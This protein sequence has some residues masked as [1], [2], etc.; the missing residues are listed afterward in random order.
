PI[1]T[2]GS[3]PLSSLASMLSKPGDPSTVAAETHSDKIR[4][5]SKYLLNFITQNIAKPAVIVVDQFEEL[6][7][8]CKDREARRM[9]VNN[10]LALENTKHKV[11]LCSTLE[12]IGGGGGFK[13]RQASFQKIYE[14]GRALL[15]RLGGTELSDAIVRPADL[16][17]FKFKDHTVKRIV[18]EI[19]TLP[20][21]LPLLQFTLIK[22][23]DKRGTHDEYFAEVGGCRQILKQ[24]A[25]EF[26]RELD[27]AD[28][29]LAEQILGSMITFEYKYQARFKPVLLIPHPVPVRFE[30]LSDLG[31]P[32]HVRTM[33][34]RMNKA[35]LIR[36]SASSIPED[37]QIE[38]VHESLIRDWLFLAQLVER[39]KRTR[40][41]IAAFTFV[42]ALILF[43]AFAGVTAVGAY[44]W[45]QKRKAHEK[46]QQWAAA[47]RKHLNDRRLDSALLLSLAAYITD[48]ADD[49]VYVR[50]ALLSSLLFHPSPKGF[51]AHQGIGDV[52]FSPDGKLL[53]A[54]D[55]DGKITFWKLI[56]GSPVRDSNGTPVTDGQSI[57]DPLIKGEQIA[58]IMFSHDGQWLASGG[59]GAVTL[60][61]VVPPRQQIRVLSAPDARRISVISLSRDSKNLAALAE[62]VVVIWDTGSGSTLPVPVKAPETITTIALSNNGEILATGDNDGTVEL[63]DVTRKR[64]LKTLGTCACVK[65]LAETDNVISSIAFSPDDE[66]IAISGTEETILWSVSSGEQLAK[67]S[68]S[69]GGV[70]MILAF[71]QDGKTLAGFEGDKQVYLWDMKTLK[72]IGPGL[73]GAIDS[74][75][76]VAFSRDCKTLASRSE[77][78]IT[79][80]DL[81][82]VQRPL[83]GHSDYITDLAF[84]SDGQLLASAGNDGI[85][86]LW[87]ASTGESIEKLPSEDDDRSSVLSL[88]FSDDGKFLAAGLL[89]GSILVKS[90]DRNETFLLDSMEQQSENTAIQLDQSALAFQ[91]NQ[92][93]VSV[94]TRDE[95]L[96][97]EQWNLATKTRLGGTNSIGLREGTVVTAIALSSDGKYLAVATDKK[98]LK[99]WN[100]SQN[101]ATPQATPT[102]VI[103]NASKVIRVLRFSRNGRSLY[104][105]GAQERTLSRYDFGATKPDSVFTSERGSIISDVALS[106]DDKTLAIAV[107]PAESAYPTTDNRETGVVILVDI[108]GNK[109]RVIGESSRDERL[110]IS[111]LAFSRKEV[112]ATARE[113][114]TVLL[115]DLNVC[116][117]QSRIC[118]VIN[119]SFTGEEKEQYS[120][121]TVDNACNIQPVVRKE[122]PKAL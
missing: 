68:V 13:R 25:E 90:F 20:A 23:W 115:W 72:P 8:L 94:A 46:A 109:P 82:D 113:D 112:L 33:L 56:N 117:A 28:R 110:P 37:E 3:K 119:R 2:P 43:G 29:R 48:P 5:D 64:S 116:Q 105:D 57:D 19:G 4:E 42:M 52:T 108:G 89:N 54:N 77:R 97:I 75:A 24:S 15:P 65:K 6:F 41:G 87:K 102:E 27:P 62:G 70:G 98:D 111:A 17:G 18:Q 63:V 71:S 35:Q 22:L 50:S 36:R 49:N 73:F 78:G 114:S 12:E 106:F 10:L 99:L 107:S 85:I 60:W 9:F 103:K 44:D 26:M 96:Q 93:L 40:F 47:S 16:V 61:N 58:P 80:W 88:A 122:C 34:D 92:I 21:A 55:G 121:D 95:Y 100:I 53:A 120:I 66:Y 14:R 101:Q 69:Q 11:I 30:D 1:I 74:T 91:D 39:K 45:W 7:T 76:S 51:L 32:Q 31:S 67:L 59:Q 38:L 79:F 83:A 118:S 86:N 81:S 84:S 104:F